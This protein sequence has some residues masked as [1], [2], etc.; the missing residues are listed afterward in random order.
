MAGQ[1]MSDVLQW[2]LGVTF[3]VLAVAYVAARKLNWVIVV[4]IALL[5]SMHTYHTIDTITHNSSLQ[6]VVYNEAVR[7]AET[8]E[9][10]GV[11]V[12]AIEALRDQ[13]L[14]LTGITYPLTLLGTYAGCLAFLFYSFLRARRL[15]S[16]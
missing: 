13:S 9:H 3:G 16:D 4:V 5:Y 14:P 15:T 6:D 7:L 1:N 11:A 12:R 2:W 10:S 8:G